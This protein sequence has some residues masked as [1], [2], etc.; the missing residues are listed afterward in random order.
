MWSVSALVDQLMG[1][2]RSVG[3]KCV[4]LWNSCEHHTRE[5]SLVAGPHSSLDPALCLVWCGH[6]NPL[7]SCM[8]AEGRCRDMPHKHQKTCSSLRKKH[9]GIS[10]LSL[11]LSAWE[12]SCLGVFMLGRR[13]YMCTRLEETKGNVSAFLVA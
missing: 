6:C 10:W 12:S 13:S 11:K 8:H 9:G 1:R 4:R 7:T 2:W 3:G 5:R